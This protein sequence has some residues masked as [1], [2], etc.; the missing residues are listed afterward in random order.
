MGSQLPFLTESQFSERLLR[1][2]PSC[3]S[4]ALGPLYTH[5]TELRR[6]NPRLSLVGPGT[7]QQVVERHYGESLAARSL[8][9]PGDRS[10][11]DVGTGA[12][13]PGLVL[14]AA[15]PSLDVTLVEPRGRKWAFLRAAVRCCGL[16]SQ[17]LNVRV[18]RPLSKQLPGEIDIV[19]CRAVSLSSRLLE[20]LCEGFPQ[21]RF[22]LWCGAKIPEFPDVCRVEREVALAG[23][24]RRR[25]LEII[26]TPKG[27]KSDTG[28]R[29]TTSHS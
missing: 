5:Y 29:D 3:P 11:L 18:E 23:S 6:W 16:S 10:L 21:V 7:A 2:S 12:G 1:V 15:M 17:C 9:L 20:T 8:I 25:I 26:V 14:A 24:H 19:S 28:R 22:L 27:S 13:F 4:P